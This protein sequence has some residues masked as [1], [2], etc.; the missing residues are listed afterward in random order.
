M[1]MRE[2]TV[3]LF[4]YKYSVLYVECRMET[5]SVPRSQQVYCAMHLLLQ[6]V[7]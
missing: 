4:P 2:M 5:K 6:Q 3:H 1:K 7:Q